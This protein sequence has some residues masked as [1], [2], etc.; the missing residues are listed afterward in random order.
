MAINRTSLYRAVKGLM[1]LTP[2]TSECNSVTGRLQRQSSA[3][4]TACRDS[5]ERYEIERRAIR[6]LARN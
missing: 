2:I 5:F 4:L 3:G 6:D 1:R